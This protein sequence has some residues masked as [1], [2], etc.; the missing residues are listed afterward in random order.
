MNSLVEFGAG[1]K[2][3]EKIELVDVSVLF[4][5][6]VHGKV[7]IDDDIVWFRVCAYEVVEVKTR[8]MIMVVMS[9]KGWVVDMVV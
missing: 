7:A 6:G 3:E 4:C 9:R 1:M 2:P 5:E 8:K